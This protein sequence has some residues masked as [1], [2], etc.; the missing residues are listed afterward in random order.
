VEPRIVA[1]CPNRPPGAAWR[2]STRL[3][4]A[5]KRT[6]SPATLGPSACSPSR[7][8]RSR[9]PPWV[10]RLMLVTV[11]WG[12]LPRRRAAYLARRCH[13]H[14]QAAEARAQHVRMA[15]GDPAAT[16]CGPGSGS[17]GHCILARRCR[18]RVGSGR[19]NIGWSDRYR[20]SDSLKSPPSLSAYTQFLRSQRQG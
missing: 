5:G 11:S 18:R 1:A 13:L 20:S 17:C 10:M 6:S 7:G 12:P 19:K 8:R 9:R 3:G 2:P 14:H 16:P 15:R 4:R